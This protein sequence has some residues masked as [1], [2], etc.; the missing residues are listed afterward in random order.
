VRYFTRRA[1]VQ[2]EDDCYTDPLIPNIDAPEP[3]AS[4]TGLLDAKGEEIWRAPNPIGFGRD[5]EWA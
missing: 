3:E 1:S 2:I 4:F 5:G